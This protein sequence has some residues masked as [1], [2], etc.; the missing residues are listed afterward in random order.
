MDK[1]KN[2]IKPYDENYWMNRFLD[3]A[4]DEDEEALERDVSELPAEY[5]Q[6]FDD[7]IDTYLSMYAKPTQES[8][9]KI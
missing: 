9:A 8:G 2:K 1:S 3:V 6:K 4:T 7:M 5:Q